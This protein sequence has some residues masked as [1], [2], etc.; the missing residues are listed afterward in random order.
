MDASLL[1]ISMDGLHADDMRGI[2]VAVSRAMRNREIRQRYAE[3]LPGIGQEQ[4]IL[5]LA[6]AYDLSDRHIRSILYGRR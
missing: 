1:T 3:L 2:R 6:D 4:A 5:D